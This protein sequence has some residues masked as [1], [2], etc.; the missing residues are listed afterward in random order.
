MSSLVCAFSRDGDPEEGRS[1]QGGH[2]C[3]G[4]PVDQSL[5]LLLLWADLQLLLLSGV[6]AH[7][8]RGD[9]LR[10]FLVYG[11]IR[12]IRTF[13]GCVLCIVHNRLR[14]GTAYAVLLNRGVAFMNFSIPPIALCTIVHLQ[15]SVRFLR[16]LQCY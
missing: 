16:S 7:H 1:G 5:D 12:V 11:F 2:Q 15:S 14:F 8:N 4:R 13:A 6:S 10:I 9:W 3:G